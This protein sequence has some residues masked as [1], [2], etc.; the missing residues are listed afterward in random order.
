MNAFNR[1]GVTQSLR[2][3]SVR[4]S[5]EMSDKKLRRK[6]RMRIFVFEGLPVVL[7]GVITAMMGNLFSLGLNRN[8]WHVII[9]SGIA[10][11]AAMTLYY[12][13]WRRP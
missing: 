4:V 10:G 13:N 9:V 6:L 2:V 8:D 11:L 3:Y 5:D 12:L 7:S 1:V